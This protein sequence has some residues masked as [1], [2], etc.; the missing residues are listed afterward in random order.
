MEESLKRYT[1]H[2]TIHFN[3]ARKRVPRYLKKWD[4]D[5][6]VI[7]HMALTVRVGGEYERILELLSG[8]RSWRAV[9]V[10]VTSDESVAVNRLIKLL[11][12]AGVSHVFTFANQE[13][14]P[15]IYAD[16]D[17]SVRIHRVL[18]G[19]VDPSMVEVCA[20][21]ERAG[22]VRDIDL[23]SRIAGNSVLGDWG[24]LRLGVPRRLASRVE[25]AGMTVD[26]RDCY[27]GGSAAWLEF[28]ARCRFQV[29]VE[30]GSSILDR[31]GRLMDYVATCPNSTVREI[32]Q[33]FPHLEAT[34]DYRALAP[35]HLEAVIAR[36]GQVLYEGEYSGVLVPELHYIPLMRDFGNLA[37]VVERMKDEAARVAMCERA[38]ADIV[39][40]GEYG[41]DR[42]ALALVDGS[43]VHAANRP[44]S[45]FL[46]VRNEWAE[47][48]CIARA[49]WKRA[50]VREDILDRI[51]L[52]LRP[53]AAR[54]IGEARL[55]AL[56]RLMRKP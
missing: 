17:E 21:I 35:R 1:S 26:L 47:R 10:A 12:A 2:E 55:S 32:H 30:T 29:G 34:V 52:T 42:F 8:F 44:V 24:Q 38:Y 40:S 39:E 31:D 9:K 56:L 4:P 6:I 48:C 13:A 3:A 27:E 16:L 18:S 22:R 33:L 41:Y 19:Y 49:P 36:C 14:V 37:E 53:L 15:L 20:E 28:L 43:G 50:A 54:C 11:Y 45:R 23:G 7:H 5:L 25:A 51:N 46:R